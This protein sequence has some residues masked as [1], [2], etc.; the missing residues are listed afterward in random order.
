MSVHVRVAAIG[1]TV[2]REPALTFHGAETGVSERASGRLG[3]LELLPESSI[4]P[5]PQVSAQE[6]WDSRCP[7]HTRFFCGFWGGTQIV[8]P[9]AGFHLLNHLPGSSV[10][11]RYCTKT[12][13]LITKFFPISLAFVPSATSSPA[14]FYR[15]SLEFLRPQLAP[16]AA[17]Q[18]F[19]S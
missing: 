13:S 1:G 19:I 6:S 11:K 10:F 5:P 12:F 18:L 4:F 8:R 14:L 9:P 7:G 16:C 17:R 15:A 2:L 3:D